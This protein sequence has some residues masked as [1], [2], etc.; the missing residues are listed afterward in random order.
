MR[1]VDDGS[2]HAWLDGA[3][4]DPAERAWIEEHLRWCAAC[5]A[6]VAEE[7]STL[8]QAHALLAVAAPAKEPPSF[9]EIAARAARHQDSRR[10]PTAAEWLLHERR[11]LQLGW[12]ATV[13]LAVGIGWF[14]REMFVDDDR[15]LEMAM[16]A[17][18][19]A[20]NPPS[21][22]EQAEPQRSTVAAEAARST[23]QR[24]A[25]G[26]IEGS[27]PARRS[28]EQSTQAASAARSA[29]PQRRVAVAAPPPPPA[30]ASEMTQQQRD[31][32][33]GATIGA[34]AGTARQPFVAP[35]GEAAASRPAPVAAPESVTVTSVPPVVAAAPAAP[36]A[37]AWRV[38]PRTEAAA[39]SGMA[40]YGLDGLEPL[41]TSIS[42]DN[43]VVRTV[44]R[45]ESGA[46]VELEQERA[47]PP[48]TANSLQAT[49]RARVAR[50]RGAS[51]AADVAAAPPVWSE[52]RGDVR[53][54]MRS[55]SITQDLNALGARLRVE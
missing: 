48:M 14:A 16:V 31:V 47:L 51:I 27:T 29:E 11:L 30:T 37:S 21:T 18:A 39:R 46:T 15:S 8:E 34:A 5:G 4:T 45:L 23:P 26:T 50:G 17:E 43:R 54:S 44:Y 35:A 52:V 2:I 24:G 13:I 20:V 28:E 7:R 19:P 41:V 38:L 3:I 10:R 40:L 12:A 6:R 55:A 53:L 42:S 25:Q 1:H 49:A 32:P 36:D 33:A 22:A 9:D